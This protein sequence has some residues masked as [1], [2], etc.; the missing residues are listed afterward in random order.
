MGKYCHQTFF[1][2]P[3]SPSLNRLSISSLACRAGFL[4][5]LSFGS[6]GSVMA[7]TCV[8]PLVSL[9]SSSL[10]SADEVVTLHVLSSGQVAYA[11]DVNMNFKARADESNLEIV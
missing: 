7:S 1:S 9:L 11:T 8:L 5:M 4:M 3:P 6:T 2:K 10:A